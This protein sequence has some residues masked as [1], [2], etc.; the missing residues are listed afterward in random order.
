[1]TRY[2]VYFTGRVQGVGFR[3][4]ASR[5]ARN[6]SVAG[7]VKNMP[8]GRVQMVAEGE[9]AELDRLVNAIV[10]TMS[11]YIR[12]HTIDRSAPS[13]EFTSAGLDIRH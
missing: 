13:S 8:D 12:E 9:P 4:T 6:F 10:Q 1:M 5:I 3:Y 11:D 7:Y 2:T